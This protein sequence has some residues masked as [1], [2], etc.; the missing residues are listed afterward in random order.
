[1][2]PDPWKDDP[3]VDLEIETID[4]K[5][6]ISKFKIL[7]AKPIEHEGYFYCHTKFKGLHFSPTPQFGINSLQAL[8]RG[9]STIKSELRKYIESHKMIL[10]YNNEIM[11][12]ETFEKFFDIK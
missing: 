5:E 2:Y 12:L 3:I 1:M 9:I 4:S 7:I 10:K 8:C 6:K 11:D